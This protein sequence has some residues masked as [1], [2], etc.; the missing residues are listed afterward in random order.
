M[1]DQLGVFWKIDCI[2][3]KPKNKI[4]FYSL[5]C[6]Y[7]NTLTLVIS[8]NSISIF[9]DMQFLFP[10]FLW[11]L[12]L[13]A[14]P[15]IIHLFYFRRF[16]KVYFTNVKFLKEVKDETSSRNKLKNL[17]I[18]LMRCL[19]IAS[20]IL[21]FA[22]PFFSKDTNIKQG[23]NA[24]SLFIDNSFSMQSLSEDVPL[25]DKSKAKAREIIEA[26]DL[27]D[28]FQ[29]LTHELS[30]KQ[31]RWLNKEDALSV[32]DEIEISAEVNS[33]STV[34]DRQQQLYADQINNKISYFIS[35][36]QKSICDLPEIKDT[37]LEVNLLAF[38]AVKENNVSIDSAW[39]DSPIPML[40]Q[41]NKLIVK[42]KNHSNEE[43]E[44]VRLSVKENGQIKPEGSFNIPANGTVTDTI[45]LLLINTGWH[46]LEIIIDDFPVQ[47]DDT[48]YLS[49]EAN[50][51]SK[52]LII[53]DGN[54]DKY[55]SAAFKG[56]SN[57]SMNKKNINQLQYDKFS[58]NSLIV[59]NDLRSL[60]SGL[61]SELEAYIANGGNVLV[62]P[63]KNSDKDSYNNFFGNMA[64]NTLISWVDEKMEV[65]KI[66]TEE[67]VFNNV[68][69]ANKKNLKLPI[70]EGRY[71]F[72]NFSSR[73]GETLLSYRDGMPFLQKYKKGG[74]NLYVAS[75]PINKDVNDLVMNAEIFI[76]MLYK[77]S[78]ATNKAK[79]AALTIG[80]NNTIEI[81]NRNDQNE[82]V[83]NIDGKDSFIPGQTNLGKSTLLNFKDMVKHAGYYD[84]NLSDSLMTRLAFNYDRTESQMDFFDITELKSN[85]EG[86]NVI[87]KEGLVDLKNTIQQKD[88]GLFLWKWCLIFALLFLAIETLLLRA[89]K[90]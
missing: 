22:Q 67:F 64:A 3:L 90:V 59:L 58:E 25:L 20:L 47:F 29:V 34:Y 61:S 15:I 30:G 82:I 41:T 70:T 19:A 73:G 8:L 10:N 89:W 78:L 62:F 79:V 51:N 69:L 68:Y 50:A 66:N 88:K 54:S 26:Y 14:I 5:I 23:K 42:V 18:L 33:L 17:L 85:F 53:D 11:A 12:L 32:L 49:F 76:P 46:D 9:V 65:F 63:N 43:V 48:Y 21:A 27:T 6:N 87:S 40:N 2:G 74:G 28:Q 35:D 81:N 31:Q 52:V 1:V 7:I 38:Q 56:L 44:D 71:K 45:N 60:S 57:F 39:F 75:A 83:Y 24:V 16:K 55:L 72:T 77:M 13:V 86:Y 37:S 84:V 80:K 36:F 4:G